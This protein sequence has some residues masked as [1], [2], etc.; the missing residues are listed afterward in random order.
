VARCFC[1]WISPL[2][3]LWEAQ[4]RARSRL[5][6]SGRFAHPAV[7][8]DRP[9][10][11]RPSGAERMDLQFRSELFNLFNI[12]N[13]GLLTSSADRVSARFPRL[14]GRRGRF[15]S[16]LS[17]ST[18][19]RKSRSTDCRMDIQPPSDQASVPM[20]RTGRM[21]LS[22]FSIC[23]RILASLAIVTIPSVAAQDHLFSNETKQKAEGR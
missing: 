5:T 19:R 4:N 6:T 22:R 21:N 17:S 10:G 1:A 23:S 15:S 11:H 14:P 2:E 12:V 9:F 13:I 20:R 8:L 3:L 16:R 18:Q 7:Q